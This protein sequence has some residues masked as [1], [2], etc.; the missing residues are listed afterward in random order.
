MSEYTV[1]LEWKPPLFDSYH[2]VRARVY[3]SSGERVLKMHFDSL[4]LGRLFEEV[5]KELYHV[6]EREKLKSKLPITTEMYLDD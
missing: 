3:N 2:P 1:E 4:P 5:K 6:H